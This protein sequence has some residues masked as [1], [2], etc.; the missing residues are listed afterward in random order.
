MRNRARKREQRAVTAKERQ[1][2]GERDERLL[3][4]VVGLVGRG[5]ERVRDEPADA[6]SVAIEEFVRRVFVASLEP[7]DQIGF[8]SLRR[9]ERRHER[10][11]PP[12]RA[13]RFLCR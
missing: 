5:A 9:I 4:D 7:C 13:W 2:I 6:R 8:R 1:R 11:S 12:G 10:T 3:Q